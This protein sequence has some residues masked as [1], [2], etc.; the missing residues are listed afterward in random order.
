MADADGDEVLQTRKRRA[1]IEC[2]EMTRIVRS[3]LSTCRS[4]EAAIPQVAQRHGL[5]L[6]G[7]H[8][9]AALRGGSA[10]SRRSLH[11]GCSLSSCCKVA[12]RKKAYLWY[13][14]S[15]QCKLA[16]LNLLTIQLQSRGLNKNREAASLASNQRSEGPRARKTGVTAGLTTQVARQASHPWRPPHG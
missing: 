12:D 11:N 1:G 8:R 6:L 3:L 7:C 13:P 9:K 14:I 5:D 16:C 10:T 4:V 2:S 15:P